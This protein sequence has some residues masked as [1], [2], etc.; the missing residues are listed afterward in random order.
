M[1]QAVA[2]AIPGEYIDRQGWEPEFQRWLHCGNTPI[3]AL[4]ATLHSRCFSCMVNKWGPAYILLSAD[5]LRL[6]K[7]SVADRVHAAGGE[8]RMGSFDLRSVDGKTFTTHLPTG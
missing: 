8:I 3:T 4:V 7:A 5:D 1:R 6:V 2:R